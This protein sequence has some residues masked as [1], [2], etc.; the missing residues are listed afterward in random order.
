VHGNDPH[1]AAANAFFD[2]VVRHHRADHF[3]FGGTRQSPR[4]QIKRCVSRKSSGQFMQQPFLGQPPI[5]MNRFGGHVQ[6]LGGFRHAEPAEEPQLHHSRLALIDRRETVSASSNASNSTRGCSRRE[7]H[8]PK[9]VVGAAAALEA[10][11]GTRHVGQ[12]PPHHRR[13]HG[14]K[15]LR[16]FQFVGR[17]PASRKYTR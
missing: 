9:A 10:S 7:S 12:N 14:K 13:T 1:P 15:W 17:P 8:H 3:R 5:S 6:G 11:P 2:P 4:H 16:S